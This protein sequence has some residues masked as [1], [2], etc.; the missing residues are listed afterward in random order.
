MTYQVGHWEH[1]SK[2]ATGSERAQVIRACC[3][4]TLR[5]VWDI[6]GA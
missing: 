6:I 2:W 5:Q 3:S 1:C 4:A